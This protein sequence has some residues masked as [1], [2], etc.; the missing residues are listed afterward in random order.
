MEL[1]KWVNSW[2]TLRVLVVVHSFDA[3]S[4]RWK[5][6]T[7]SQNVECV[8]SYSF[9]ILFN[10]TLNNHTLSI[11]ANNNPSIPLR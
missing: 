6:H 5:A 8:T 10:G 9:P 2:G 4:S 11:D 3:E 1:L 7:G